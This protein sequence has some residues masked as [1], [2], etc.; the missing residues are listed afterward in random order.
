MLFTCDFISLFN[1][2]FQQACI[3]AVFI[4]HEDTAGENDERDCKEQVNDAPDGKCEMGWGDEQ[5]VLVRDLRH[6]ISEDTTSPSCK[7]FGKSIKGAHEDEGYDRD[8]N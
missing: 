8:Q 7:G 1:T 4:V 5:L 2:L 6:S 3:L